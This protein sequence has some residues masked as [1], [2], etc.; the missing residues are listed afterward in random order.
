MRVPLSKLP[1]RKRRHPDR[2]VREQGLSP[3][4]EQ[5]RRDLLLPSAQE[6]KITFLCSLRTACAHQSHPNSVLRLV[7]SACLSVCCYRKRHTKTGSVSRLAYQ[8]ERTTMR[9]NDL[10]NNRQ[11]QPNPGFFGGDKR[12]E[13]LLLQFCRHSRPAVFHFQ[14]HPGLFVF[15]IACADR[16]PHISALLAHGLTGIHE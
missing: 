15:A 1:P 5:D 13:Y 2:S 6:P 3:A 14:H 7:S 16:Y 12:I 10:G 8:L 9:V 11:S 4:C